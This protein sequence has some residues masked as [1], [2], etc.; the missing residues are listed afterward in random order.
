MSSLNVL[1]W[2][3]GHPGSTV[4]QLFDQLGNPGQ[5]IY[6][7]IYFPAGEYKITKG[8]VIPKWVTVVNGDG[9]GATV[10]TASG[11]ISENFSPCVLS[12]VRSNWSLIGN[13]L[14][15]VPRRFDKELRFK[16]PLPQGAIRVG[17]VLMLRDQAPDSFGDFTQTEKAPDPNQ[18]DLKI[19]WCYQARDLFAGELLKVAAITADQTIVSLIGTIQYDYPTVNLKVRVLGQVKPFVLRDLTIIGTGVANTGEYG[20]QVSNG[21]GITIERVRLEGSYKTLLNIQNCLDVAISNVSVDM[22]S[23]LAPGVETHG[24]SYGISISDSQNVRIVNSTSI[25]ITHAI[26][27]GGGGPLSIINRQVVVDNCHLTTYRAGYGIALNAHPNAELYT[28]SNN[29]C[30][31]GIEISGR[32]GKVVGNDVYTTRDQA[33]LIALE[34]VNTEFEIWNNRFHGKS[35]GDN[36]DKGIILIN[37]YGA[38]KSD[39]PL[40]IHGN[41]IVCL[42][43]TNGHAIKLS[44][45]SGNPMTYCVLLDGN[46][47]YTNSPGDAVF[48]DAASVNIKSQNNF[49]RNC[50]MAGATQ[51]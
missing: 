10:I 45:P 47:I 5:P 43:G 7:V 23:L 51:I 48:V 18:P 19:P 4:N 1:E 41:H 20:L 33:S 37:F 11:E 38:V 14:T 15:Q 28:F 50:S 2:L 46:Y 3:Q 8:I 27:L 35:Y 42:N 44:R 24:D 26:T 13:S 31:G 25:G 36:G 9:P 12:A 34:M 29:R 32:L 21:H 39:G 40:W 22:T 16:Q 49:T 17:N 30:F 6:E